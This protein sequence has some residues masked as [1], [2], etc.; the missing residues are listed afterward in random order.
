MPSVPRSSG[1]MRRD[2]DVIRNSFRLLYGGDI[3]AGCPDLAIQVPLR[4][5][6]KKSL[7]PEAA[8]PTLRPHEILWPHPEGA[9]GV[10]GRFRFSFY[11]GDVCPN[12]FAG[13]HSPERFS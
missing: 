8:L 12:E 10:G 4:N 9:D 1:A 7:D 2:Q 11:S 5:Q 6:L 3:A 13:G